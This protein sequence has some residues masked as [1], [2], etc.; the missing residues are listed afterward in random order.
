MNE[1][2]L[3]LEGINAGYGDRQVLW[4]I[5]LNLRRGDKVLLMGPNGSGKSTLLKVVVGLVKPY[6]GR[7]IFKQ[8]EIT[9]WHVSRR[10][11][12][13]ILYLKQYRNIFP[14]LSVVENLELS[15]TGGNGRLFKDRVEWVLDIFPFLS[16]KLETRVGLLSGGERQ[17]LAV[18]MVFMKEGDVYL[19]D[20][21]TAGL[22][23][24][25]RADILKGIEKA[26]LV[27]KESTFLIVE[28][29]IR[30]V[31]EFVDRVVV[32]TQGHIAF[33]GEPKVLLDNPAELEMLYFGKP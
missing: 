2:V 5:N 25:A 12:E 20:E 14:G 33:D 31:A 6:Q 17:A 29:N 19:L 23:P 32:M 16:D 15:F 27:N 21:P 28:H 22:S 26:V 24:K 18:S 9:R 13:G 7:V 11:R 1:F 4:D 10:I 30:L 8:K 3:Q